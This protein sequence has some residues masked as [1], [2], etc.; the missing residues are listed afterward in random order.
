V[1]VAD[2]KRATRGVEGFSMRMVF[3]APQGA[4]FKLGD[5][6]IANKAIGFGGQIIERLRIRIRG[7]ARASD[8]AP[9]LN[10]DGDVVS[11]TLER[12]GGF[13]ATVAPSGMS[14]TASSFSVLS[15]E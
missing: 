6:K 7:V 9:Y 2:L 5:V 1:N 11:G 12:A 14:R 4:G 10:C 3:E 8:P 13:E 15:D